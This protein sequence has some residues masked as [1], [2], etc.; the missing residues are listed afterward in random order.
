[1]PDSNLFDIHETD[2]EITIV[3][4]STMQNIDRTCDETVR[5]LLDCIEGIS[6]HLFSIQLVMR[7][8]LTN[9]VRHGNCLDKQKTVTYSV[10]V[11]SDR[12]L[13]MEIEDQG[14]GFNWQ[15]EQKKKKDDSQEHGRG[16]VIMGQYF[17]SYWYNEIGNKLILEK[18]I[19]AD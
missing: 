14:Q 8:G 6:E 4:S 19:N 15:K 12:L 1:M 18:R 3:F 16:L 5:F 10:K 17:S 9:A 2:G 7:E 13:R 11:G